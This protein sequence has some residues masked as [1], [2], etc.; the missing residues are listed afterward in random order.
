MAIHLIAIVGKTK[1]R[2][3]SE[4]INRKWLMDN[5]DD[6]DCD[7]KCE[8]CEFIDQN[9]CADKRFF[10]NAP[11]IEPNLI[12]PERMERGECYEV[13]ETIVV[14]NHDDYYDLLCKPTVDKDY[15]IKLIQEAVY[16]GEA[17]GR[18]LDLVDR[19]QGEWIIHFDDLFPAESTEEC[20]ICHAEQLINGND[21]NFCPHCGA[22]MFPTQMSE[23]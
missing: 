12:L 10:A 17:C 21:D 22:R 13:G 3:M 14:L 2:A 1:E 9:F 5:I 23:R 16:D 19:P 11:T 6:W 18:L 7:E 20:P 15:L 4:L 8:G